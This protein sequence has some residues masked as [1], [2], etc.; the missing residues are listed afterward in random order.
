MT[1]A[2]AASENYG[3]E[4][5]APLVPLLSV[6]GI[7]KSF[8]GV[9]A[10]SGV[11]FDVEAGEV[12]ALLGENG[13]GKST[14]IKIVSGVFRPDRGTIRVD[15][16]ELQLD[17]P[18]DARRAGIATIYQELLLF[19]ELSVAENVFM[20]HAPKAGGGRL[21]WKEMRARTEALLASLDIHDLAP[22]K[23][24]GTLS[25]GNRQRVEILRALS[26]DARLLIMDEPTAALT[27]Y[28]VKRLFDIV[29]RLKSRGVGIIYISHRMDEIFALADSRNRTLSSLPT[30]DF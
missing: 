16:R 4:L 3:S 30:K 29:R 11:A 20:G 8:P 15:G 28:D 1:E 5:P 2:A 26:Q 27:E 7:E 12:H 23:I 17:R 22:N 14:L 19:P 25:V 13:A 24:V 18:D 9:C 6:S 10:L 21:D